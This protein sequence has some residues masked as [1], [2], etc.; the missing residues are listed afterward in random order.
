ML[1]YALCTKTGCPKAVHRQSIARFSRKVLTLDPRTTSSGVTSQPR[2]P[3]ESL[4]CT[5]WHNYLPA[6][7]QETRVHLHKCVHVYHWI[8]FH[9]F[10][11]ILYYL[12]SI[13][14]T[15]FH[16]VQGASPLPLRKHLVL[17][18]NFVFKEE[19]FLQTFSLYEMVQCMAKR[20]LK[21]KDHVS[22]F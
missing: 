8:N 5:T 12:R 4:N 20:A 15:Q 11:C 14:N 22:F 18:H 21:L 1:Q 3:A 17:M 7:W 6:K 16:K 19:V 2:Q 10:Q 13:E 9:D